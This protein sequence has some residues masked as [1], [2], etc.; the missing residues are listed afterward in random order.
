MVESLNG[1]NQT[2]IAF[3]DEVKQRQTTAI[4]ATGKAH[5]ET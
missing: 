5:D 2:D 1:L 4:M 3:L